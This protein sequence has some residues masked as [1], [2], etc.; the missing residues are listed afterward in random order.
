M[1]ILLFDIKEAKKKKKKKKKTRSDA[2]GMPLFALS[3]LWNLVCIDTHTDAQ[4]NGFEMIQSR[5]KGGRQRPFWILFALDRPS[6]KH[7]WLLVKYKRRKCCWLSCCLM[8]TKLKY[9]VWISL[10]HYSQ[11]V[12]FRKKKKEIRKSQAGTVG[13][14]QQTGG[15]PRYQIN[16]W[17]RNPNKKYDRLRFDSS[18]WTKWSIF[19]FLFSAKFVFF[20]TW[21]DTLDETVGPAILRHSTGIHL[22]S[23]VREFSSL[24]VSLDIGWVEGGVDRIK[25]SG[26]INKKKYRKNPFFFDEFSSGTKNRERER[27]KNKQENSTFCLGRKMWS[28]SFVFSYPTI[29]K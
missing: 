20:Y 11:M 15:H 6:M 23:H 24:A 14:I 19:F 4:A 26:R 8:S 28:F 21:T 3:W 1:K 22:T 25:T 13:Q 16:C 10:A 27:K 17:K 29:R 18:Y 5:Q 12:W 7:L 9:F 2:E